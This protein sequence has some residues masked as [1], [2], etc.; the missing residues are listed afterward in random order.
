MNILCSERVAKSGTEGV[1][2]TES[3]N[4][5]KSLLE[6]GKVIN[7]KFSLTL[8]NTNSFTFCVLEL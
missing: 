1:Q 2:L 8:R 4:I 5:N 6:L 7:C 3:K